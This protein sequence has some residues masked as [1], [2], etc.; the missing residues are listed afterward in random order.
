MG[1]SESEE[2][3]EEERRASIP[4]G[5]ARPDRVLVEI[6]R[7]LDVFGSLLPIFLVTIDKCDRVLICFCWCLKLRCIGGFREVGRVEL[8][9]KYFIIFVG[10]FY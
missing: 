10:Y 9:V 8:R 7:L 1:V 6:I 5:L 3:E 4:F 2:E